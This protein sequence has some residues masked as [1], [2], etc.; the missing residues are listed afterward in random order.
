MKNYLIFSQIN[1]LFPKN[2]KNR[3]FALSDDIF[4]SRKYYQDTFSEVRI[5]KHRWLNQKQLQKDSR[6]LYTLNRTFIKSIYKALNLI[7]KTNYSEKFWYMF[8]SPWSLP[9]IQIVFDR[10]YSLELILR[11]NKKEKFL[12][13]AIKFKDENVFVPLDTEEFLLNFRKD[14]WNQFIVQDILRNFNRIS[15]IESNH[16]FQKKNFLKKKVNNFN[17]KDLVFY[18]IKKSLK[19]FNK[20]KDKYFIY[21][22]YLGTKREFLLCR[23]LDQ[24]P[25][26]DEI[27]LNSKNLNPDKKLRDLL[28]EEIKKKGKFE[29]YLTKIFCRQLPLVF[30][31]NFSEL[32]NFVKNNKNLPD[33]PRKIFS[34]LSLWGNSSIN[35]YCA[36]KKEKGTKIIYAQHGGGYGVTKTHFNTDYELEVCDKYLSYGWSNSNKKILKFGNIRN[37]KKKKYLYSKNKNLLLFVSNKR[38]KYTTFIN[39]SA[40]PWSVD[41]IKTIKFYTKFLFSLPEDI[42]KQTLIRGLPNG[43][44]KG[45][46]FFNKFSANFQMDNKKNIFK[47]Y[48]ESKLVIHALNSTSLLETFYL[49]IPSIIVLDKKFPM[50][51]ISKKIFKKLKKNNI[52]FDNSESAAKFIKKIWKDGV[53]SWWY[54]KSVQKSVDEFNFNFSKEKTDIILNLKKI[55]EK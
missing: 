19:I 43:D 44:L 39:T 54:S 1:S 17:F 20:K 7:H 2:K 22:T 23:R 24:M 53:Y 51:D 35:Y 32:E 26:F 41:F 5:F 40:L 38:H 47:L 34:A 30:L 31:E 25:F 37:L 42:K 33:K 9:F 29:E 52:Y 50:S 28:S 21:K 13:R 14:Y 4:Y 55:L 6:Y 45:L 18:I 12:S 16:K 11:K 15:L 36:Q 3:I 10:W 49:N 8:I 48:N 27:K 46:D